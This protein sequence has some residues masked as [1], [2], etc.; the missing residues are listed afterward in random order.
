LLYNTGDTDV[1]RPSLQQK[2]WDRAGDSG[3]IQLPVFQ[4]GWIWDDNRIKGLLASVAKSFPIGAMLL[5]TGKKTS[6]LKQ[7]RWKA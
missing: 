2:F 7:N 4:R 1:D 6:D 3:K 5:E